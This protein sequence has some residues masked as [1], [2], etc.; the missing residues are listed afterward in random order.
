MARSSPP[1]RARGL[2]A[3]P[4]R[5][6]SELPEGRLGRPEP[7]RSGEPE[8]ELDP[9]RDGAPERDGEPDREELS[10]DEPEREPEPDRLDEEPPEDRDE[11]APEPLLPREGLPPDEGR[12]ELS[13]PDRLDGRAEPR[14]AEPEA[15]PPFEPPFEPPLAGPDFPAGRPPPRGPLDLP[16]RDELEEEGLAMRPT[17]RPKTPS[18]K[19]GPDGLAASREDHAEIRAIPLRKVTEGQNEKRTP[20]GGPFLYEKSGGVLLSQGVYSQVPSALVGL[21]SVFGMGTG[22]TPPP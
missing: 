11:P 4:E 2:G 22:V 7:V 14:P 18:L 10:E 8:R 9:E 1:L 5:D 16:E 19:T 12:P 17:Y 21:T 15:E 20:K 3:F 6:R 13:D